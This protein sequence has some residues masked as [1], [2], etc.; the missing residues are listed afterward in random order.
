MLSAHCSNREE[1]LSLSMLILETRAREVVSVSNP[2]ALVVETAW[3]VLERFGRRLACSD[4]PADKL[5]LALEAVQESLGADAVWWYSRAEEKAVAAGPKALPDGWCTLFTE[6]LVAGRPQLPRQLLRSFL[7]PAS[8]PM[9]PWPCSAAL[10]QLAPGEAEWLG[11]LSFHP[12]RIF[13]PLDVKI[14]MLARRIWL[15]HHQ[16]EQLDDKLKEALF[17]LVHCLSVTL[18]AKDKNMQGHSERVARLAVRLG[19]ALA[20]P[21]A[22]LADL[23]LAGLLHDIG[24]IG[25]RES[26]LEKA[27]TLTAAERAHLEEHAPLGDRLLATLKPL[28]ALRLGVRGH[29]EHYDGTG[30]PDRLRGEEI[31]L[32][33]RLLAVADAVDAMLSDRPHRK[34]MSLERV[35][36]VLIEG[37]GKQWDPLVVELFLACQPV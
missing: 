12:R 11:A 30:Y 19:E 35:R 6:Q 36:E 37:A 3:D 13:Q 8:K 2:D 32:Q 7:D 23:H 24:K 28:Q 33:A 15:N 26:V 34:A 10:V 9:A 17:G 5:Q 16:K 22:F 29:H 31:P 1:V 25:I 18:E 4:W 21:A 27:G 14:M 20:L